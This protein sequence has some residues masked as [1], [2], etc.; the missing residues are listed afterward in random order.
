[1]THDHSAERELLK[2]MLRHPEVY[3]LIA[4][5]VK[6]ELFTSP[7]A[8][9][10][11]PAADELRTSGAEV[12]AVTLSRQMSQG[13]MLNA[14]G[15]A[16]ISALFTEPVFPSMA[17]QWLL[18]I[19]EAYARREALLLTEKIASG[20]VDGLTILE[21][22]ER[23]SE[24]AKIFQGPEKPVE[25][26][27]PLGSL[28]AKMIDDI[29]DA[30]N[31]KEIEHPTTGFPLLDYHI[32]GL[33]PS[34]YIVIAAETSGG[35]TALA[36][37]FARQYSIKDKLPSLI[38]TYEMP[39]ERLT[40]RIMAADSRVGMKA[41][42]TGK[43]TDGQ[44]AQIE[45]SMQRAMAAPLHIMDSVAQFKVA[46]LRAFCRNAHRKYGFGL[47][48]VDYLQLIPPTNP[49]DSRERQVAEIS[50]QLQKMAQ[51]LGVCV[52]TMS[53]VNDDGML[54]ESRAI[55]H[56][57][58]IVMV[59]EGDKEQEERILHIIKNRD[60]ELGRVPILFDGLTQTFTQK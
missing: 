11:F 29:E 51:E 36:L 46:E 13:D 54:R 30:R 43:F 23:A 57:A 26:I 48:V 41:L 4:D 28:I 34:T 39:E 24:L 9:L 40:K 38:I 12:G 45:Q 25:R 6:P 18:A 56:D 22:S 55:G 14:G 53:Q 10:V 16:E 60:G 32:E 1:M 47:I 19:Q 3:D 5:K 49:K 27:K 58:D 8:R 50:F 21:L 42:K 31:G 35:K 7:I 59:I 52:I 2:V 37:Q 33:C 20:A 17:T 44:F 15:F